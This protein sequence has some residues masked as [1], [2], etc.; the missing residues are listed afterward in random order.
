VRHFERQFDVHYQS[1]LGWALTCLW[2]YP[3]PARSENVRS[4]AISAAQS[5]EF[6]SPG[7]FLFDQVLAPTGSR[8]Q[9]LA[10]ERSVNLPRR[11]RVWRTFGPLRQ[12]GLAGGDRIS[13]EILRWDDDFVLL[14]L[15]SGQTI[16]V[17]KA[18]VETLLVPPGETELLT[19]GFESDDA[20]I[21]FIDEA[22]RSNVTFDRQHAA[23]GS[24][25][26]KL[27]SESR[28][29]T[30]AC[31]T[32]LDAAR[33]RFW[34]RADRS[35]SSTTGG[36]MTFTFGESVEANSLVLELDGARLA[37]VSRQGLTA[38]WTTQAVELRSGWHC[39]TA[40][41]TPQ[42][43]LC[44]VDE[45]LLAAGSGIDAPLRSIR[46]AARDGLWIDDLSISRVDEIVSPLGTQLP[47]AVDA[48]VTPFGEEFFG[49]VTRIAPL[50]IRLDGVAGEVTVPWSRVAAVGFRSADRP[51][52]GPTSPLKGLVARIEWQPC[53]DRPRLLADRLTATIVATERDGLFLSHPFVGEFPLPW[54]D[55]SRIEP[56]FVGQDLVLDARR[57]HLG[58]S[59]RA[60][61]RRPLPDGTEWRNEFVLAAKPEGDIWLSL[62]VADLE[63][64]GMETP[65]GSPFLKDLRAGRLL[66]EV[67]IND[68]PV[69]DLNRH[70]RFRDSSGQPKRLRCLLPRDVFRTGA[71]TVW[72][73]QRPLTENGSDYD[74]CELSDL[75][76]ELM[77]VIRQQ[78]SP[79]PRERE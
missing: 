59:I 79:F 70:L 34:F 38:R 19:E 6:V 25:S 61:F 69:G 22:A 20:L 43:G 12:I 52:T 39:L 73:R 51:L 65:P 63:P 46:V 31:P 66:T 11:P 10:V 40:L 64:S 37:V 71:N 3:T 49:R 53:V 41:L 13:A 17:P 26:W 27:S 1:L 35:T 45:T 67:I 30:V 21:G 57:V 16:D 75:R 24:R 36:R 74:D 5:I 4:A 54:R 8:A 15:A 28:P 42:R 47:P 77:A 7:R 14:R 72:L 9:Q 2:L 48:V 58:D 56:L 76:L 50:G 18:A 32:G 29:L 62:N 33:V 23:S 78:S 60:D 55:I 44:L 68:Q